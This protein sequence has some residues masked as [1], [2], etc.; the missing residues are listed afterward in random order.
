MRVNRSERVNERVNVRVGVSERVKVSERVR[1]EKVRESESRSKC[2][3]VRVE[4]SAREVPFRTRE[5]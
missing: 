4:E 5:G 3:R 2:G 1:V